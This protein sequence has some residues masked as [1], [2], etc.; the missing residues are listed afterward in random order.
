MMILCRIFRDSAHANDTF[1]GDAFAFAVD[2][3]YQTDHGATL[4]RAPNFYA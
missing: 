3:H 4:N 2:G 1:T